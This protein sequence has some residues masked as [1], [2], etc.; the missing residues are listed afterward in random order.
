M[1]IAE[2]RMNTALITGG[3]KGLGRAL[4]EE[5]ARRGTHVILVARGADALEQTVAAIRTHGGRANAI[6]A[7]VAS[8]DAVYE[9]AG[10]AADLAGKPMDLV[11]H[12]AST[13]GPSPMPLLLDL[14]CEDFARV[15][16]VNL[17][18]PFRLAKAL[19]GPMIVRHAGTQVFVSSDAAISAYA[20]W[21]VYSITKAAAD[22]MC[23]VWAE[24]LRG[25]GVRIFSVDPGEMDT[26]MH[27][28][29]L[30]DADPL[31]L[32]KPANVARRFLV[33]LESAKTGERIIL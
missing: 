33:A 19:A 11:I 23:R 28:S 29:A 4:S 15:A 1:L 7:D 24:E 12:A 6:A 9:I 20:G 18:G 25:L 10:R 27:R 5:L 22:H 31:S 3:S 32:A 26:E 30:P 8:K 2:V 17:I 16:E 14:S 13:L 21:G